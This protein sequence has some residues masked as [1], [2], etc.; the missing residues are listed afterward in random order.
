MLR[1]NPPEDSFQSFLDRFTTNTTTNFELLHWGKKDLKIPKLK[2]VMSDELLKLPENTKNII[3]NLDSKKN[4]GTHWVAIYNTPEYKLYFSS[5]GDPPNK[6]AITFFNKTSTSNTVR[7]YN[8]TQLQDF[9]TSHCGIFAL[10]LLYHLNLN[11]KADSNS[12]F[13][14]I[15][16][17]RK[18]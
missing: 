5:F 14:I 11:L 6:Q 4:K 10:Y 1:S 13:E 17:F 16:G 9:N 3:M 12:A 18:E 2:I 15:K 8:D 7:E